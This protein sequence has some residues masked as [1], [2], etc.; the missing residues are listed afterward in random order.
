MSESTALIEDELAE[1][2]AGDVDANAEEEERELSPSEALYARLTRLIFTLANRQSEVLRM[3]EYF[4]ERE[5]EVNDMKRRAT[6]Q[7]KHELQEV[8]EAVLDS[9]LSLFEEFDPNADLTKEEEGDRDREFSEQLRQIGRALPEGVDL[10]YLDAMAS[11]FSKSVGAGYLHSSLLMILVGELEMFINYLARACFEA[12]PEALDKSERKLT[13]AEISVFESVEDIRDAIVDRAVEDLLRGSLT[14]WVTFF[15][16]TFGIPQIDSARTYA[17]LEAMQRR[18]C[19][20]HNGSFVSPRY[21]KNLRDFD[22]DLKVGDHLEVDDDYLHQAADTMMLV[23]YSLTWALGVKLTRDPEVGESLVQELV[24]YTM[25]LLQ[26]GRF[27]LVRQ[28]GEGALKGLKPKTEVMEALGFT[29]QVNTWIAHK[30]LGTFAAVERAIKD[31]PVAN[32]SDEFKLAK[33]A[34]L[35]Q[36]DVAS[37]VARRMLD[38]GDLHVSSIVTWP[39]LRNIRDLVSPDRAEIASDDA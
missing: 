39:L 14:D 21:L 29:L 30:E 28:I 13:W 11:S 24:N 10:V 5:A 20:V 31:F 19:I 34:L 25:T 2:T 36:H 7:I 33:A 1:P 4:S 6:R 22:V 27:D 17:V 8:D 26:Q 37:A 18:H 9:Y 3:S 38:A 32:R 12:S 16:T 35:D 15:E 23:A